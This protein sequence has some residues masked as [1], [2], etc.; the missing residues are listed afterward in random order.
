M[1]SHSVPGV[2]SD[3]EPPTDPTRTHAYRQACFSVLVYVPIVCASL[4]I[5][6]WSFYKLHGAKLQHISNL[7][8]QIPSFL[9]V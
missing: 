8:S 2:N 4:Q 5:I 9:T 3:R 1:F 7:R 6:T